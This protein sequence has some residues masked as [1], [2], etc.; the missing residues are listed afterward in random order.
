ME[1]Y[2]NW[3]ISFIIAF[4]LVLFFS[5]FGNMACLD[6]K[7]PTCRSYTSIATIIP[8]IFA[9]VMNSYYPGSLVAH[10]AMLYSF[11]QIQGVLTLI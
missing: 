8:L 6:R 3:I 7:L 4:I 2:V 1:T 5:F 9:F 10:T 11:G